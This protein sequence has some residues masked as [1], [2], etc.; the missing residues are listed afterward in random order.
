MA[1]GYLELILN[2]LYVHYLTTGSKIALSV[3]LA[4]V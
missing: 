3:Y 2:R 1:V 4:L